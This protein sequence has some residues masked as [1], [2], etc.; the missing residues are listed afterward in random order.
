[1][2]HE[3]QAALDAVMNFLDCYSQENLEG[4]MSAIA[5]SRPILLLGTNENEVFRT[6]GD[7]RAA[8]ARDFDSMSNIRWGKYLNIHVEATS[9]LACVLVELPVTYQCEGK[10]VE[11][12]FRYSLTLYKEGEQWKICSGMA[13]VPFA[14]GTYLF[15]K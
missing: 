3:E 2:T 11:T 9:T 4:C 12:M 5:V 8:F 7:I 13:S 10:D 14:S 6:L 15:P 1:M